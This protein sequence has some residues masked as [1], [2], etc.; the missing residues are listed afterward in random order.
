MK[1]KVIGFPTIVPSKAAIKFPLN[2]QAKKIAS[3]KCNPKSG[4]NETIEPH[5][6][7]EA[8]AYG[9]ARKRASL[10]LQ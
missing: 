4:V 8:I 10:S 9:D 1:G 6:K 5:A 2:K 7:P 3:K